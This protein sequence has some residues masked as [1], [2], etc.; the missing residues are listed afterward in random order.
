MTLR[1]SEKMQ[2]FVDYI[3]TQCQND[4]G[5]AAKIKRADNPN[6]EYYSWDILVRF[7]DLTKD[8]ERLPYAYIAAAIADGKVLKNGDLGIGRVLSKCYDTANTVGNQE[9]P[10]KIKLRRLL[11]CQ[12]TTEICAALRP[13]FSL[14]R[15]KGFAANLDYVR[16]LA[17]LCWF[18]EQTKRDW[19]MDF[20]RNQESI[21]E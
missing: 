4:K 9:E 21:Y 3:I 17:N 1:P 15:A 2:D 7:I 13:I 19:A 6:T 16:L 5:F 11:A 14:I 18:N 10:A 20:Y 12:N 8:Y